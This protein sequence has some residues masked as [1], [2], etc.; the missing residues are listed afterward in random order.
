MF[1]ALLLL[2]YFYLCFLL[3]DSFLSEEDVYSNHVVS[4]VITDNTINSIQKKSTALP[5]IM[6]VSC[7]NLPNLGEKS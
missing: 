1:I 5:N 6:E 7:S 2:F 3:H 4:K